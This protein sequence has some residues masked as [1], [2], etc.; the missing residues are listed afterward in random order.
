[1]ASAG[2]LCP[3]F[4]KLL[5]LLQ[6]HHFVYYVIVEQTLPLSELTY[7]QI[8]PNCPPPRMAALLVDYCKI[9]IHLVAY[10]RVYPKKG[11]MLQHHS[12]LINYLP[13]CFEDT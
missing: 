9:I 5:P 12:F 2:D 10:L 13:T 11:S 6:L 4:K 1:M 3:I 8:S 7:F